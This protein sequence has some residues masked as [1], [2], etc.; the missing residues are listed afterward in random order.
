MRH[1]SAQLTGLV[2]SADFSFFSFLPLPV[3]ASLAA[4]SG[5]TSLLRRSS[6]ESPMITM[7]NLKCFLELNWSRNIL[8][9]KTKENDSLLR[10]LRN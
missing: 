4:V 8:A 9:K 7:F 6:G 10:L 2:P 1:L 3:S 5:T